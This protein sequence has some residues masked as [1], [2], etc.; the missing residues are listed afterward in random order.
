MA[1]KQF[2]AFAAWRALEDAVAERKPIR[3]VL[4]RL[5]AEMETPAEAKARIEAKQPAKED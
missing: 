2:D 5:Q 1:K 3:P 4:E